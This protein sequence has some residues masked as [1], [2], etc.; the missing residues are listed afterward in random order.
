VTDITLPSGLFKSEDGSTSFT[1]VAGRP[2]AFTISA[3][4]PGH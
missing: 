4:S 2:I 3:A 1:I